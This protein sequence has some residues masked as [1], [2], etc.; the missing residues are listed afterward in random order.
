MPFKHPTRKV[1]TEHRRARQRE[2]NRR[3]NSK[4]TKL[5]LKARKLK[6]RYGLTLEQAEALYAGGCDICGL[7][8]PIM[9][10]DHEH[11]EQ[12]DDYQSEP[13]GEFRGVLCNACNARLG[14]FERK[15]AK[16]LAY[17]GRAES[18]KPRQ[19]IID[20]FGGWK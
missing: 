13:K 9:H 4:F 20:N 2:A 19:V 6:Y 16:V 17:L 1:A 5:E 10:I 3:Y 14:W 8:K 15:R 18:K 11:T 12:R 7:H